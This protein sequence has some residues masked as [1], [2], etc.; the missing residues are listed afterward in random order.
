[1]PSTLI[2]LLRRR[3]RPIGRIVPQ[4]LPRGALANLPSTRA[5]WVRVDGVQLATT[6]AA[7]FDTSA[8][9]SVYETYW[10]WTGSTTPQTTATALTTCSDWT[11][12]SAAAGPTNAVSG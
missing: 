4:Q 5:P 1:M 10:I 7:F 2:V 8:T 9:S 11:S 6:A 12:V 3:K